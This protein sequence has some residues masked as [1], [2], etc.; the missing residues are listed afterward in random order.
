MIEFYQVLHNVLHALSFLQALL[1]ITCCLV[2]SPKAKVRYP[3]L[4]LQQYLLLGIRF[5]TVWFCYSNR[6]H[7]TAVVYN[8]K[9]FLVA[10]KS[11]DQL[12]S[13]FIRWKESGPCCASVKFLDPDCNGRFCLGYT[14]PADRWESGWAE[15]WNACKPSTGTWHTQCLAAFH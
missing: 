5:S 14:L 13:R 12:Y 1:K 11:A 9:H 4:W 15:T 8:N 7:K 6:Q 3:T 2:F 10:V